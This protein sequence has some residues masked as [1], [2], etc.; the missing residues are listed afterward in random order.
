[1]LRLFPENSGVV[2]TARSFPRTGIL[3]ILALVQVI[4]QTTARNLSHHAGLLDIDC[5]P[6]ADFVSYIF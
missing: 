3:V 1:M 2:M 5:S 6:D 4:G